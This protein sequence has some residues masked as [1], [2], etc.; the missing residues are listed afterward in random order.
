MLGSFCFLI[1]VLVISDFIFII[2]II[3]LKNLLN[4]II[5]ACTVSLCLH[6]PIVHF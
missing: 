3:I 6:A 2:T 1:S 5:M 4:Y